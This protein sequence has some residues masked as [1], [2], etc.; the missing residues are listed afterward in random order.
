M[1]NLDS[2]SKILSTYDRLKIGTTSGLVGGFA[3]FLIIFAIDAQLGTSQGIFYKIVG[4]PVGLEG[5]SATLF[6]L[7]SH[8]LVASVIGATFCYCSEL[9]PKLR[10]DSIRKGAIA[11]AVTSAAVYAF[12]FLPISLFVIQPVLEG[13]MQNDAGLIV[14]MT[15]IEATNLVENLDLIIWGSLEIHIIFG[16]IMGLFCAIAIDKERHKVPEEIDR[17][18]KT[19]TIGVIAATAGIGIYYVLIDNISISESPSVLQTKLSQFDS[20]LTFR[21]FTNMDVSQQQDVIK[22]L[23]PNTIQLLLA[24]AAKFDTIVNEDMS[25]ITSSLESPDNL[26]YVQ[27]APIKGLKGMQGTGKA[28]II[29]TGDDKFLRFEN[30][31]MTNGFGLY[32]FLTKAG[33]VSSGYEIARL[34]GNVGSQNYHIPG[35]DTNEYNI[36]VIYSK[37]F[38]MYYASANLPKLD[39]N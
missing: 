9:H 18:L 35:I 27:T 32:V 34:K 3:I 38:D 28:M 23:D 5:V 37:S 2:F 21:S 1:S 33:D 19:I 25:M 36:M 16:L 15:N 31:K 14:T 30:L 11:G 39:S 29:S 13:S 6:G 8:M 7:V 17:M 4:I 26:K 10:L 20:D 22:N 24:E 12:F